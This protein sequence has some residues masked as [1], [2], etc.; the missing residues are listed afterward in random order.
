LPEYNN[1]EEHMGFEDFLREMAEPEAT[2]KIAMPEEEQLELLNEANAIIQ[3]GCRF[4]AGDIVTQAKAFG[5][6]SYPE[7]GQ[8][9]VVVDVFEPI[10]EKDGNSVDREDMDIMVMAPK[11]PNGCGPKIYRVESWRFEPYSK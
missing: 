8:P 4:K 10:I 9:A 2:H 1:K 5:Q 7:D 6:Y 11:R 3:A